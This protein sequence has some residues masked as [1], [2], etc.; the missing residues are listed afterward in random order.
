MTKRNGM[1]QE[2]C[3]HPPPPPK[4]KKKDYAIDCKIVTP[5]H[6]CHHYFDFTEEMHFW[7]CM[8]VPNI[9]CLLLCLF[10]F[11][12]S[13]PAWGL[14]GQAV[15]SYFLGNF[16]IGNSMITWLYFTLALIYI[17]F[18]SLLTTVISLSTCLVFHSLSSPLRI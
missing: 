15:W 12:S 6:H 16:T 8:M 17:F 4:K 1:A 13:W 7:S 11:L 2:C 9:C 10:K 3:P 5:Y 18:I 14:K